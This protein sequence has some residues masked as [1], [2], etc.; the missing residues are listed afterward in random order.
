MNRLELPKE[1]L[2]K[3]LLHLD[4]LLARHCGPWSFVGE[5]A[6]PS[7][8][9]NLVFDNSHFDVAVVEELTVGLFSSKHGVNQ[10]T[11]AHVWCS[12]SQKSLLNSDPQSTVLPLQARPAVARIWGVD[13]DLSFA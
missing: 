5:L 6:K 8:V 3:H 9:Q 4:T 11:T 1:L 13:H 2:A 12:C 10:R 7:S